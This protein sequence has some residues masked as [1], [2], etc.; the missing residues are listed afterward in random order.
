MVNEVQAAVAVKDAEEAQTPAALQ[1][2]VDQPK[3]HL[4]WMLQP[5]LASHESALHLYKAKDDQIG[6]HRT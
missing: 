2:E 6:L 5:S 1:E 4:Q 3:Q